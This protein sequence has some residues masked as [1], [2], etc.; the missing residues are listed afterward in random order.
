MNGLTVRFSLVAV[1]SVSVALLLAIT[2]NYFMF[3]QTMTLV[4]E[5][6]IDFLVNSI[7]SSVQGGLDLGLELAS[8]ENIAP[9]V[10][11]SVE[12]DPSI[13]A[14]WIVD[15]TGQVVQASVGAE[16]PPN[17]VAQPLVAQPI[18][19]IQRSDF[20]EAIIVVVPLRNE[21]GQIVGNLAL[22]YDISR[23]ESVMEDLLEEFF[24]ISSLIVTAVLMITVPL[25]HIGLRKIAGRLTALESALRGG[26]V[27]PGTDDDLR[28]AI[29][30]ARSK[31][32]D[33][34]QAEAALGAKG[35]KP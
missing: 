33:L 35:N 22:R 7:A 1:C 20:A 6:R 10:A 16:P 30:A 15:S 18:D 21:I 25:V 23:M 9:L 19:M 3:R 29:V 24:R 2:L 34:D 12:L 26:D 31:I 32:S 27:A 11:R 4:T 5:D 8:I 28:D 17:F 13:A 14:I